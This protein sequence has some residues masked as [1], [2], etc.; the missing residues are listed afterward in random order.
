MK[1]KKILVKKITLDGHPVRAELKNY[2]ITGVKVID[3]E[4]G[5]FEGYA[6]VFGNVDSYGDIVEKGAFTETIKNWFPRYPKL[7]ADH[8]WSKMIGKIL[9][10]REDDKGLYFKAK[11]T[12]GVQLARE[13]WELIKDGA[14][15]DISFGYEVNDS[16]VDKTGYRHLTRIT[17]YEIS[18]VMVGANNQAFI[19]AFKSATAEEEIIEEE[20]EVP[21]TTPD[22]EAP[23]V[24]G[25]IEP[26]PPI[27]EP[28]PEEKTK[29]D[30]IEGE[31]S[32]RD[33]FEAKWKNFEKVSDIMSAFYSVYFTAETEVEQFSDLV[34]EMIGLLQDVADGTASATT[35][36][37]KSLLA[38]K[39]RA[40]LSALF[41]KAGR[42]LSEKN[43]E[44]IKE[45]IANIDDSVNS[46]A[47]V[48]SN[49]EA[50]LKATESQDDESKS[51][52]TTEST[53]DTT[54]ESEPHNSNVIKGVLKEAR[55]AVKANT[56]VIV[57]LKNFN[58]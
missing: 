29:A 8:E 26:T 7:V 21:D 14:Q 31:L 11:L 40:E 6:S 55:R 9:E 42:V 44:T 22:V 10:L 38:T 57:K 43:R 53:P 23:V 28:E 35:G 45:A 37:V 39:T 46:L 25:E 13:K 50:L 49:F 24:D 51:V 3:T 4:E 2:A 5:I 15:T 17:A 12:L 1:T 18:P 47:D 20:R 52:D 30:T 36:E 48:K 34:K 32:D 19:T 27:A 56:R 16:Y 58:K 54:D 41:I 33:K